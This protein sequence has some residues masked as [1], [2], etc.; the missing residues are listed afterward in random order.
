MNSNKLF[1]C[2]KDTV[3]KIES[4]LQSTAEK[5][6]FFAPELYTAF[7][8]GCDIKKNSNEIFSAPAEWLRETNFGCG[9]PSD[10]IF[11]VGSEYCFIEVKLRSTY[12]AYRADI[13]KLKQLDIAHTKL[14]CVLLDSFT[15]ANDSR[16]TKLEREYAGSLL[17]I[18]H[19]WF[20]TWD[21]WYKKPIFCNLNLYRV[22]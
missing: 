1:S 2:I 10:I 15:P 21:N 14:F 5:G 17:Q 18:G 8:I 19:H 11:K 16:L 7:S 12:D 6:I 22:T 4:D 3:L 13:Q 20:P 9:G